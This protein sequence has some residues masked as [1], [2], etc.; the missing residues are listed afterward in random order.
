[1][2]LACATAY[3]AAGSRLPIALRLFVLFAVAV[4]AGSATEPFRV[5]IG[6]HPWWWYVSINIT[7]AL[8]VA[9]SLFIVR[10]HR[11]RFAGEECNE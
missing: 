9:G 4:A 3:W 8:C 5:F 1:M 11:D 10:L 7:A 2:G 6:L